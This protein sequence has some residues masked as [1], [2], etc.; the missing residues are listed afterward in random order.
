[1]LQISR[2]QCIWKVSSWLMW[3]HYRVQNSSSYSK[4][5]LLISKHPKVPFLMLMDRAKFRCPREFINNP[6]YILKRVR[7]KFAIV[8]ND[9]G[10]NSLYN[11]LSF[12]FETLFVEQ[13]MTCSKLKARTF[14]KNCF[15]HDRRLQIKYRCKYAIMFC[16]IWDNEWVG[17]LVNGSEAIIPIL[18]ILSGTRNFLS[19][20]QRASLERVLNVLRRSTKVTNKSLSSTRVFSCSC[21]KLKIM[22]TVLLPA[23]N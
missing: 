10:T 2:R 9:Q 21:F 22:S 7:Y 15:H 3:Y 18:C 1:M 14:L 16:S 19:T 17:N 5:D 13:S 6:L 23:R 8:C 11:T 20:T 4:D 12:C